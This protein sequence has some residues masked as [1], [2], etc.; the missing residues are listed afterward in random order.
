MASEFETGDAFEDGS[1]PRSAPPPRT[2]TPSMQLDRL[3]F[4]QRFL[5][6][7]IDPAFDGI[8]D[9][10]QKVADAASGAKKVAEETKSDVGD[11]TVA[12]MQKA[13]DSLLAGEWSTRT[14]GEGV[15]VETRVA[16]QITRQMVKAKFGGKS[17][18][19]AKF[20]GLSD[21][22]RRAMA[23]KDYGAIKALTGLEDG[24]FATNHSIIAYDRNR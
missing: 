17:P 24:Q 3:G 6:Q 9:E 16:R 5:S 22:E 23:E 13:V 21:E 20:T 15:S 18:E 19:W 8:Q 14:A 10:L 2:G 1:A 11:T 12:M 4:M 7:F